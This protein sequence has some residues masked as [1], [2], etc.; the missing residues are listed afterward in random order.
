[1]ATARNT[2]GRSAKKRNSQET[3]QALGVTTNFT[4]TDLNYPIVAV[5]DARPGGVG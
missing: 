1:M 5:L 3:R 4:I 2:V